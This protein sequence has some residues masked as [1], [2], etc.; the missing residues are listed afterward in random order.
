MKANY[1]IIDDHQLFAEAL[2]LLLS[3]LEGMSCAEKFSSAENAL[4]YCRINTTDLIFLDL[5]M[6]GLN[7]V[8]FLVQF[9]K[10]YPNIPVIVLTMVQDPV[11]V[12]KVMEAGASGYL[13]KNCSFQQLKEA[14]LSV[15]KGDIYLESSMAERIERLHLAHNERQETR[16]FDDPV[17]QLSERQLE[18]LKLVA[19]GYTYLEIARMTG[20]SPYTVR[21]HRNNINQKLGFKNT[22][23]VIKYC[24]DM[25]MI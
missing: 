13:A 9:R 1:L 3:R 11:V 18:I 4:N 10:E 16:N 7:G 22:A 8:D 21:T 2:E 17:N 25:G 15:L 14:V 24:T 23:A 12:F 6:A 20:L 5:Q 19:Q